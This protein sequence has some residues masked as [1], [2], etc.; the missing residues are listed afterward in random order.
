MNVRAITGLSALLCAPAL[1]LPAHACPKS[2]TEANASPV[3]LAADDMED[4]A[5]EKD[6]RPDEVPAGEEEEA[7]PPKGSAEEEHGSHEKKSEDLENEEIQEDMAPDTMPS[8][9]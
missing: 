5:V 9:E 1:A 3:I 7:M 4:E 2:S 6:L 8:G